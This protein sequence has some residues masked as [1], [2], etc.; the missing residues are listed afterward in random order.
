MHKYIEIIENDTLLVV[1]RINVTGSSD[2]T[3]DR[4]ESGVNLNLNHGKFHTT[5]CGYEHEQVIDP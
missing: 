1:H 4:A 5:V 3:I 2:R